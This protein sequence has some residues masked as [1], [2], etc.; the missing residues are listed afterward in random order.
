M[1]ARPWGFDSPS[2]HSPWVLSQQ[3]VV[4][5]IIATDVGYNDA[6][7]T[8]L[9]AAVVFSDWG[10]AE[11]TK[12]YTLRF[13]GV[14]PYEPGSFYKRELPVL[15]RLLDVIPEKPDTVVVDGHVWLGHMQ[16]GLGNYLYKALYGAVG[17]VGIAKRPFRDGVARE[18]F[19]GESSNPLHVTAIGSDWE[20]ACK[21]VQAMHGPHRIPTLLRR[22]DSL[23]RGR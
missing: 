11:P 22:V 7:Q 3:E 1:A 8:A 4:T 10:D 2:G 21:G 16:P 12:E 17:V 14:A 23:S 6:N 13:R 5:T 18:V 19:R 9:A 15:L 20:D